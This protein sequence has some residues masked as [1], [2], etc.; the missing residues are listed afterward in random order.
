MYYR[1]DSVNLLQILLESSLPPIS[2]KAGNEQKRNKTG[3]TRSFY[4]DKVL[5]K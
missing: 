2:N 1:F 5:K 3:Q 4:F